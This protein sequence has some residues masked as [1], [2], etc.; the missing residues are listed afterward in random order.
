M[1]R[2]FDSHP[3]IMSDNDKQLDMLPELVWAPER[4]CEP[5]VTAWLGG[6]AVDWD[7]DPLGVFAAAW[8]GMDLGE[9]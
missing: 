1:A 8:L 7:T 4:A 9:A 6:E 3:G 2:G 5:I